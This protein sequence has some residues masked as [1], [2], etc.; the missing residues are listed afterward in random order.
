MK[1]VFGSIVPT[2]FRALDSILSWWNSRPG[3][4]IMPTLTRKT[5]RILYCCYVTFQHCN[6]LTTWCPQCPQFALLPASWSSFCS[7]T[8]FQSASHCCPSPLC[9]GWVLLPPE[10]K[11]T[12]QSTK[13]PKPTHTENPQIPEAPNPMV[14]TS[15]SGQGSH[16]GAASPSGK[17]Q[18]LCLMLCFLQW[19]FYYR[20]KN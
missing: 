6:C 9:M 13:K 3:W 11:Q 7:F 17:Q 18:S 16:H 1:C 4:H 15:F 20:K 8:H 14:S 2:G 12:P 19:Q 5:Q 10:Q